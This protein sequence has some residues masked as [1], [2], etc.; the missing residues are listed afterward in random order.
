[1]SAFAVGSVG[2]ADIRVDSVAVS[3]KTVTLTLSR[4]VAGGET[5]K[6]SYTTPTTGNNV[7]QDVAGND[8]LD[9]TSQTVSNLVPDTTA[10]VLGSA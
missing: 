8:A 6:L 3:G 2:N 1:A 9:L 7:I 4:T 10:P 5:V